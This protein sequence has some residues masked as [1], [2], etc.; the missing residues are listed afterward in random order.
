MQEIVR[1]S[2]NQSAEDRDFF[3][4]NSDYFDRNLDSTTIK[5]ENFVKY[6]PR[7]RLA[8][9]LVHY[10]IFKKILHVQGSIVECGVLRGEGLFTWAKL[11]A[12][13]EPVNHTRK[14]VGFDTFAGF[15]DL[16]EKDRGSTSDHFHKGGL[17]VDSYDDIQQGIAL[18]DQNRPVGHIPKIELVKGDIRQTLPQ[19]LQENPHLVV[20]LLHLDLDIYEPTKTAIESLVD[21]MPR[22]AVLVFD[23]L[24]SKI[25]TGETVA[26]HETLGLKNLRIERFPF[27]SY[28][29]YAVL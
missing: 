4:K 14:I 20:S 6:I 9:F 16:H 26:V 1:E 25:W 7:Q 11:S 3:Q 18:Y 23:E 21:R 27:D 13:F 10:E 29:S 19:Y 12:I 22:G 17:C 15:P 2:A 28:V 5:L 8:K 24:N